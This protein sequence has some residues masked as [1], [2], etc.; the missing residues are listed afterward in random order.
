MQDTGRVA[1][2]LDG[3]AARAFME[4]FA[5]RPAVCGK[6]SAMS[7][8]VPK[9]RWLN[10]TVLGI[11]L[12]S[13]FSDWSHEIATALMPAFLGTMGVAAVWLGLIEGL[14]DGVS[15]FAKM[16]SGYYTDRLPRRK[17]I[18]VAGYLLTALG[19][20]AFAL[21]SAPWHLLLARATAWLGRGV[22]TPVRKALM[23][24]EVPRENYGRAFGFER[25]MDTIGAII[26]P[27]TA[28]WLLQYFDYRYAPVFA[29][30]LIPGLLAAAVIAFL[31]RERA[32]TPVLHISFGER[33]RA[34]PA[35]YRRFLVAVGLFGAG[36]FAHTLLILLAT[37]KLAPTM[38]AGP[39]AA[40]AVALYVLHNVL[41]AA[42]SMVAGWLADRF[43]KNLI[44]AGGYFL[45][46]AMAVAII[47]LP[48][49]L[50][51]LA[52]VFAIGGIYIAIEETLEDSL[53][54][55]LVT[56]EHHGMAFG[57]LATVNGIGDMVSSIMVG[58]LWTAFG[59]T[60]AFGYSAV[61]FVAGAVLVLRLPR[62]VIGPV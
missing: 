54:A 40:A 22:R 21:A 50:W 10:R 29:A 11:G 30:T 38:G 16:A 61:L 20:A 37:Q 51:T 34:L 2:F 14:S 3:A 56:P 45:A 35:R 26:G 44:L 5:F 31:V 1:P 12:A 58:A 33:L 49:T 43:P 6:K 48:A 32:R 42:F 47:L 46:A 4:A 55:E 8:P 15:S 19:T 53:C 9:S 28:F 57:V 59:T 24:A 36:D 23:A 25:M 52:L 17:P 39:A 60:A 27:A 62:A 41:Y 18:A 13:L 7:V